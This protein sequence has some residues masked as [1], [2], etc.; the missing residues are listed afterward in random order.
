MSSFIT[1]GAVPSTAGLI[2]IGEVTELS[3]VTIGAVIANEMVV[4]E[5]ELDS[6]I[7]TGGD[8]PVTFGAVSG[9]FGSNS[10]RYCP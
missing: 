5:S 7:T 1:A 9:F 4:T 6:Y 3:Y 10:I 2:T 8:I